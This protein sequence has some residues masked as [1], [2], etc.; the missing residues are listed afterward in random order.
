MQN[1]FISRIILVPTGLPYA[2]SH[3]PFMP[4]EKIFFT[5]GSRRRIAGYLEVFFQTAFPFFLRNEFRKGM[6][7]VARILGRHAFSGEYMPGA[8][9]TIAENLR[10]AV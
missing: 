9:S 1:F 2:G 10:S 7:A 8:V 6:D 3:H 5:Y 4:A